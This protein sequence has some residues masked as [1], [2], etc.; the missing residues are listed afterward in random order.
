MKNILK[1]SKNNY[2]IAVLCLGY[3]VIQLVVRSG[4]YYIVLVH[5][6]LK[7]MRIKKIKKLGNKYLLIF[8]V[9]FS[10][11]KNNDYNIIQL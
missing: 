11:K 7:N 5:K 4:K 1:F 9:K 6:T 3:V 8:D 10:F 2:K